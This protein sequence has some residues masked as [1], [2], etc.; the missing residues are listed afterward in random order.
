MKVTISNVEKEKRKLAWLKATSN[1][2]FEGIQPTPTM[3][4]I[5]KKFINGE[6]DINLAVKAMMQH[7]DKH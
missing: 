2:Y 1:S 3:S 4:S 5:A 6:Y 7:L